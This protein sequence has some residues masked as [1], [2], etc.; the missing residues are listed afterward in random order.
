MIFP[1]SASGLELTWT[2][3]AM[4]GLL[5]NVVLLDQITRSYMAVSEWIRRGWA[6]RWGP[7]HKFVV[8]F[9]LGASLL[10]AVWLGFCA[11]GANAIYNPPP[12][13]PDRAEA[14]ERGGLI[15]V[16]LEGVM[17]L[18]QGVLTWAWIAVGKPTIP[19]SSE[20]VTLADLLEASTDAGRELAHMLANSAQ[21]PVTVL[22]R[23]AEDPAIS[24]ELREDAA[25]ALTSM[26]RLME[27]AGK[28]HAEIKRVG[29]VHE[30]R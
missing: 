15:L 2:A 5:V 17:L 1:E 11:L 12:T 16:F 28:L 25:S 22:E 29:G 20:R 24:P 14:S 3:I 9:L 30:P 10:F 7:R 8:G 18:F 23:V 19:G 27:H 6:V 4:I 26:E 21:L 13:T